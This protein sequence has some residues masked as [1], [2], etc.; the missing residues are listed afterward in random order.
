MA[1]MYSSRTSTACPSRK[2]A[3]LAMS[4]RSASGVL[5][6]SQLK[7]IPWMRRL[8]RA[9]TS[10]FR[11]HHTEDS[12]TVDW[13]RE[14]MKT[15]RFLYDE[16]S[17]VPVTPEKK[18]Q[19]VRTVVDNTETRNTS[20]RSWK[21]KRWEPFSCGTS[22]SITFRSRPHRECLL[23]ESNFCSCLHYVRTLKSLSLRSGV[24]H[25]LLF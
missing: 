16:G 8:E 22:Q 11:R 13:N 21:T 4:P 9:S 20:N 23:L 18:S 5:W 7:R 10:M 6:K 2:C 25:Y 14:G 1:D 17:S 19:S 15:R 12:R 24:P 3:F